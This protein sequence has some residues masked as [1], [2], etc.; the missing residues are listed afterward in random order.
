MSFVA[1]NPVLIAPKQASEHY[2]AELIAKM[3]ADKEDNHQSAFQ[4]HIE[5]YQDDS[6]F[7]DNG[8]FIHDLQDLAP[9]LS[10]TQVDALYQ[11]LSTISDTHN[12]PIIHPE[13]GHIN[14]FMANDFAGTPE[15][16]TLTTLLDTH[17]SDANLNPDT[18]QAIRDALLALAQ[19]ST[20]YIN[21]YKI[22]NA[23]TTDT[24]RAFA[25]TAF[26]NDTITHTQSI[27]MWTELVHV[28]ILN[29][30]GQL[31]MHT[32]STHYSSILQETNT[33]ASQQGQVTDMLNTYY[34]LDY[35]AKVEDF[36]LKGTLTGAAYYY[37]HHAGHL[38]FNIMSQTMRSNDKQA[39][40]RE[41]EKKQAKADQER[42]VQIAEHKAISKRR[43][44][45]AISKQQAQRNQSAQKQGG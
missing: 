36:N 31:L 9:E 39:K 38:G 37:A 43:R 6:D 35:L 30:Y 32:S 20:N 13:E 10:Q 41:K 24:T 29:P 40:E 11:A 45:Q 44:D 17:L 25:P 7:T 42:F 23:A 22:G 2:V 21:R 15:H 8:F 26:L 5:H 34:H 28:G 18:A 19:T 14:R 27:T 33:A 16:A 3:E 4:D 12:T 1:P